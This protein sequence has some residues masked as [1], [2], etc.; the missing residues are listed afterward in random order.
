MDPYTFAAAIAA[1]VASYMGWTPPVEPPT[2]VPLS[3]VE[4]STYDGV[5]TDPFQ[6][7]WDDDAPT[8]STTVEIDGETFSLGWVVSPISGKLVCATAAPC[9]N[10]AH[11]SGPED[12]SW[13]WITGEE[14]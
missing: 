8:G 7:D 10:D 11:Y 14:N 12:S 1:A 6:L 5:I 9:E 13:N 4:D 3:V 2:P